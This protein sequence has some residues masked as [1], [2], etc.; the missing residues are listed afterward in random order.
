MPAMDDTLELEVKAI[1][2]FVTRRSIAL[3]LKPVRGTPGVGSSTCVQVGSHYLL[4][5]AGHVI[6][7]LEDD[8]IDLRAASEL[9]KQRIPFAARSCDPRRP[10]PDTDVAWIELDART[11][12][13]HRLQ[14]IQLSD[15][16]VVPGQ[17]REHPFLVQGYPWASVLGDRDTA[18][19]L[20]LESTLALTM[21][22]DANRLPQPLKDF[23]FAVE[24]PPR[25]PDDKPLDAP[26]PHGMSGGGTWRQP[27]HDQT[28]VWTPDTLW[29]VGINTSWFRSSK[30]LYCTK[31]DSWL[32]LV[33]ND[34]PDTGPLVTELLAKRPW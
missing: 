18:R 1:G 10:R 5:T 16:H 21:A 17:T 29:L 9:S 2:D 8:Q 32:R 34:F 4:A 11:V 19:R 31:I 33:A 15:I 23:E 26:E 28:V 7:D 12:A 22:A 30:I 13:D 3:V 27:R 25:G 14:F 20:D 24:Y 6:E